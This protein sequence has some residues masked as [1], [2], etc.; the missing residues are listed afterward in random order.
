MNRMGR[1]AISV[2]ILSLAPTLCLA[3]SA[4]PLIFPIPQQMQVTGE[5]FLITDQTVIVLPAKPSLHDALLAQFLT[6]ELVD[7]FG[8][9]IKTAYTSNVPAG[10]S[11]IVMGSFSNP[12]VKQFYKKNKIKAIGSELSP[13]G[14]ILHIDKDA[15]LIA[16]SDE[17]GA[18]YGLQSLRQLINKDTGALSVT[19]MQ[20]H[21]WPYKPFRA[22]RLY[23]P[24]KD[25]LQFF[26]RFLHNF[27]AL[28][29]YNKVILE[30]NAVMR[31]DRH[32]ELNAGAIDFAKDMTY[33]RRDRSKGPHGVI[34]DSG[35]FDAGDGGLLEKQDVAELVQY[36]RMNNIEVIPEIPSLTHSYYLLARHRE[37][38]EIPGSEWPD[39]YCPSN[40]KTYE[41]LFDV[42][43]EYIEVM[44]PKMV[45][46][47]HDEW[48][49]PVG[50]CPR[51][52]DKNY[53][54]LFV[55]D[56]NKIYNHLAKKGIKVAMW[57]DQLMESARGK[58][59]N[60]GSS[61]IFPGDVLTEEQVRKV[62]PNAYIYNLPG[63]VPEEQVKKSI[64]K[65]ILVLNWFWSKTQQIE[66]LSH[67]GAQNDLKLQEMGFNQVYGNFE[68]N[69]QNWAERSRQPGILGGAPSSWAATTEFNIGKDQ[70]IDFLGCANLLWSTHWPDR[71]KLIEIVRDRTPRI[72]RYLS[73]KTDPSCDG[74]PV[75]PVDLSQHLNVARQDQ[76]VSVNLLNLRGG[77]ITAGKKKFN[78]VDA[79][80]D[81]K[82]AIAVATKGQGVVSL[83]TEVPGIKIGKD[84]TS[85]IFL[86]ACAVPSSIYFSYSTPY[87]FADTADLLGW[88]EI[89]Y[90]D[91]FIE[92]IP[93]RY[94]V[95][96][97]EWDQSS[98]NYCYAAQRINCSKE[99][100]SKPLYFYAFEWTN[101]RLGK[102]IEQINLKGTTG[103]KTPTTGKPIKDNA[104][105][106]VAISVIEKRQTPPNP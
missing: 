17:A 58:G 72:H 48:R 50:V 33:T 13:E 60:W 44:Q 68:A 74:D 40:P 95:N 41:L 65:D 90:E 53:S 81:V 87:N 1:I 105:V 78:V 86:H 59:L 76:I 47:A 37:L 25:N 34:Q 97:L 67:G 57:C 46:I 45:N 24:G 64:P 7:R 104:V 93:I 80:S 103:F 75:V 56:V 38:A 3:D 100:S 27:M 26:K 89:V 92:T 102:K 96:I 82:C 94:G 20:V 91:G 85:L 10:R 84:V 66:G 19:G 15:I 79:N 11:V 22:L 29:K 51:C 39:T 77:A 2:V 9:A 32:P 106:L 36:A 70:M 55:E 98:E 18:F 62:D 31:L 4:K 16:G 73:G 101:A 5:N 8:F 43:D 54:D 12:L 71:A 61:A 28:Y 88:Y 30:M 83:P 63:G 14:Y 99:N 49:M 69:I 6:S 35:N 52:K 23:V 42:L 21:D